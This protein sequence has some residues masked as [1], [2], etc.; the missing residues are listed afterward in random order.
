MKDQ[1]DIFDPEAIYPTGVK[2]ERKKTKKSFLEMTKEEQKEE[3]KQRLENTRVNRY[4]NNLHTRDNYVQRL[5]HQL[6]NLKSLVSFNKLDKQVEEY[7]KKL[8][9]INEKKSKT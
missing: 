7:E 9:E 8:K 3:Y 4:V 2:P 5:E 6:I 1:L